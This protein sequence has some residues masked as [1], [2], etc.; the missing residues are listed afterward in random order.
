MFD[1]Y[2]G[3]EE[4][5]NLTKACEAENDAPHIINKNKSLLK[6]KKQHIVGAKYLSPTKKGLKNWIKNLLKSIVKFFHRWVNCTRDI[7]YDVTHFDDKGPAGEWKCNI[8]GD[9]NPAIVWPRPKNA[10]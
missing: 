3:E 10:S 6:M 2:D 4:I 8:C 9:Y 1:L 5:N 7:H